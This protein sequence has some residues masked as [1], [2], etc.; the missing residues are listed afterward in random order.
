[1]ETL[2]LHIGDKGSWRVLGE[3]FAHDWPHSGYLYPRVL[4]LI[5]TSTIRT[6]FGLGAHDARDTLA[7]AEKFDSDIHAFECHPH[8]LPLAHERIQP[9]PPPTASASTP[10]SATTSSSPVPPRSTLPP[11]CANTSHVWWLA[12]ESGNYRSPASGFAS[13]A[14]HTTC[15]P[16]S[17]PTK[18]GRAFKNRRSV[19]TGL[20][21]KLTLNVRQPGGGLETLPPST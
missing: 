9:H 14:A 7:L 12:K 16:D 4:H 21:I 15:N 11:A 19:T 18:S 3:A 10:G 6:V 5:H 17:A 20:S 2:N 8:M 1:M 13:N